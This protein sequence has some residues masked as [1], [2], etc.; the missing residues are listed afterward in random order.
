[1]SATNNHPLAGVDPRGTADNVSCVLS[2]LAE[3]VSRTSEQDPMDDNAARGLFLL[4]CACASAL[5]PDPAT[6][7]TA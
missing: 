5:R 2:F 6:E 1:M 3:A 4:L 7:N